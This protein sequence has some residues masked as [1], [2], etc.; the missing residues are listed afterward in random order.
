MHL[1]I[2]VTGGV[3][4]GRVAEGVAVFLGM[5]FAAPPARFAAPEPPGP[6]EGVRE[7][8][9]FGPPPPQGAALGPVDLPGDGSGD[10]LTL[11]VW[12]PWAEREPSAPVTS[13]RPVLLWIQGGGYVVG[14][15]GLPEYDGTRLAR[16]GVVVVTLN[17][18]VGFEGFGWVDGAPANRGLL[19]QVAALT[20]VRDNIAAFGGDPARVTVVGQSAGAGCAAALMVM[21][22]AAGLF[23]RVIAQSVPGA[24]LTPALAADVTAACAAELGVDIPDLA[25]VEPELLALAGDAVLATIR[26]RTDRWGAAAHGDIVFAPV[27]DGDVLPSTPWEGLTGEIDLVVGHTRD[28]QRLLTLLSGLLGEVT[29]ELAR[30]SALALAPDPQRYLEA[31]PDPEQLYEVVRSDWLF[32]MPSLHLALAQ[33][34]AG[35]RAYL[36]ELTWPAPGMGGMLGACHGLDVALVLGN[37]TQGQTAMLLGEVTPE[38]EAM[39]AQLRSAWVAFASDGDP[40]WPDVATGATRIVDVEPVATAYPETLSQEIWRD[41]PAVLDLR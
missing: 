33:A 30:E 3:V 18:R 36:Y 29:P 16:D 31:Y 8:L 14:A 5:P 37:L 40:G 13:G 21:P 25:Q 2:A 10:W 4:R 23:A 15:S 22:R 1:D 20:W 9:A 11:N 24:F 28:E 32:R 17:Y 12:A 19:D 34:A 6:W 39:S 38:V 27:V 26:T 41:P 35:G 7:A